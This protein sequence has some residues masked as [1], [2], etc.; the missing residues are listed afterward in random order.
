[1][2]R[3]QHVH[4]KSHQ[5]AYTA[6][7]I[8]FMRSESDDTVDASWEHTYLDADQVDHSAVDSLVVEDFLL[9]KEDL[10]HRTESVRHTLSGILAAYFPISLFQQKICGPDGLHQP[11]YQKFE[12]PLQEIQCPI[13]RADLIPLPTL[14]LD[15]SSIAGTIDI[16]GQRRLAAPLLCS[17][18]AS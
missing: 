8:C 18:V 15:E 10:Q 5:V 3:D 9:R 7:Y 2:R 6:G 11:L 14:A 1:M 13:E 12:A 4:N 17:C 16:C